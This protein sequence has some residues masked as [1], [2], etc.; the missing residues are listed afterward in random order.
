MQMG[1]SASHSGC[2]ILCATISSCALHISIVAVRNGIIAILV[3]YAHRKFRASCNTALVCEAV[4]MASSMF[5][6]NA[7]AGRLVRVCRSAAR[8]GRFRLVDSGLP[9]LKPQ[10]LA[11]AR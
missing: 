7:V 6:V 2:G 11:T 1:S 5:V 9:P 10:F 8:L 4:V 3:R